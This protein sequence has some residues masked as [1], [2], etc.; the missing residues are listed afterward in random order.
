[1]GSLK[2]EFFIIGAPKCGT[3]SMAVYLDQHP[4][5]F[6]CKPKEPNF[7]ST[8]LPKM[9]TVQTEAEYLALF[10]NTEP[11]VTRVGEASTWYLFSETAVDNILRFQPDA[12]LVVMLRDPVEM[13]FSLHSQFI[14]NM[15]ESETSPERAWA[16]QPNEPGRIRNYRAA[17]AL[18]TQVE[19]LLARVPRGQ[20]HFIVFED[21]KADSVQ[22]YSEVLRFL[23]L[24]A[25]TVERLS[26]Y[27]TRK[28]HKSRV[29]EQFVRRPPAWV[30]RSVSGVKRLLGIRS[31]GLGQRL[32]AFNRSGVSKPQRDPE[33][34][35]HLRAEFAS[36][37]AL[38]GKLIERDLSDW[39]TRR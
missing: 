37:V 34:V 6:V 8:D 33:F 7:F 25:H 28:G 27:N 26:A 29:L 17:C 32:R 22:Q 39:S 38:L 19:R 20:I 12:K 23:D 14:Y 31:L 36:E 15:S 2:P 9:R 18:G 21:L 4:N 24:P 35:A 5:V 16:A 13:F 30:S 3:T 11:S 1:M 10:E